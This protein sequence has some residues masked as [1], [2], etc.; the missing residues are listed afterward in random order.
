M[1]AEEVLSEQGES[2]RDARSSHRQAHNM[3]LDL[4]NRIQAIDASSTGVVGQ[5]KGSLKRERVTGGSEILPKRRRK[6]R[7]RERHLP[8][9]DGPASLP[10][11][12]QREGKGRLVS[13][14]AVDDDSNGDIAAG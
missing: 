9:L 13:R 3:C 8:N 1:L 2:R 6:L 7:K 14:L 12:F 5:Q 4:R 10:T 11:P